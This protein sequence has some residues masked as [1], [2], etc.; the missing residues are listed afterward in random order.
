MRRDK[1]FYTHVHLDSAEV[2]GKIILR[3]SY[4]KLSFESYGFQLRTGLHPKFKRRD[5]LWIFCAV[6]LVIGHT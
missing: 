1:H 3:V 4:L 2:V 6:H 5:V